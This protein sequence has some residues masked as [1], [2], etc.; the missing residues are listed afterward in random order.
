M[1]SGPQ[2][3]YFPYSEIEVQASLIVP[4]AIT[5]FYTTPTS[6]SQDYDIA[7]ALQSDMNSQTGLE[8]PVLHYSP[9]SG[10]SLAASPTAGGCANC[11]CGWT[12]GGATCGQDDGTLC[13]QCCCG[14]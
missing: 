14:Q 10:F 7:F 9:S 8:P 13:W 1:Y 6:N 5:A 11:D 2:N 12:D 3:E 4:E